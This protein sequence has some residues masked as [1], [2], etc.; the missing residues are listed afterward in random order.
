MSWNTVAPFGANTYLLRSAAAMADAKDTDSPLMRLIGELRNK[1]YRLVL[2]AN[3][4]DDPKL[5]PRG[6]TEPALL[7]VCKQVSRLYLESS[8]GTQQHPLAR[9]Q[10]PF[11]RSV[12][13]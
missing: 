9:D 1:I 11:S 10:A 8:G 12:H 13:L 4:G 6:M 3:E 5:T 7:S 2:L